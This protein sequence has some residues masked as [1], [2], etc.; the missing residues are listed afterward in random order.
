[1]KWTAAA[2]A[3]VLAVGASVGTAMAQDRGCLSRHRDGARSR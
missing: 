3:S 1:M 2:L